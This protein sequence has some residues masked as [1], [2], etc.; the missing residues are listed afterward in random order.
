MER[1]G[2]QVF[3]S[4]STAHKPITRVSPVDNKKQRYLLSFR[5]VGGWSTANGDVLNAAPAAVAAFVEQLGEVVVR[6]E[7][8]ATQQD[9]QHRL[10]TRSSTDAKQR[11]ADVREAM[12]PIAQVGRTLQGTVFGISAISKMPNGN[13][14][15]ENLVKAAV[16]MAENAAIFKTTLIEHGL[17]PNCIETLQAAAAALK[18]SVDTRG[19]ARSAAVGATKGIHADISQGIKLVSLID[20]GLRPVLRNNAS[21]LAS[22]R[23]AKRVTTKGVVGPTVPSTTEASAPGTPS[24]T[25]EVHTA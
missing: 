10:S 25:T 16:S 6:I 22:W 15:N 21:K 1:V 19:L 7:Y 23:N 5:R 20:A 11:R 2:R 13:V 8:G 18:S 17:Q 9:V 3:G 4:F 14:D 24:A 12:R